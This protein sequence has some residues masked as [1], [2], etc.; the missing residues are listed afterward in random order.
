MKYKKG[1]FIPVFSNQKKVNNNEILWNSCP[2]KGYNIQAMSKSLFPTTKKDLI[3]GR[4]ITFG[5][6]KSNDQDFIPKASSGGIIPTI[7]YY[8]L[9]NKYID[10]IVTVKFVY[11]KDGPKP[12][13]FIAQKKED[14][15]AAQGSKYMPIPLLENFIDKVENS[16]ENY[17]IGTPCQI[18]AYRNA[19]IINPKIKEDSIYNC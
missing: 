12:E 1:Q 5:A 14:L 6:A 15:I 8:L 2:G 17:S 4:Y 18:A 19:S 10:G 16:M 11:S 7:S 13:P 3:L 9:K